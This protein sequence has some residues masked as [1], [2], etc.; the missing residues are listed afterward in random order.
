MCFLF[1]CPN[2][3]LK[4]LTEISKVYRVW[5]LP[6]L[7]VILHHVTMGSSEQP[8]R[9]SVILLSIIRQGAR[10]SK[11]SLFLL[12]VLVKIGRVLLSCTNTLLRLKKCI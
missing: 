6:V 2:S 9:Y 12:Q 8:P 10:K 7:L 11:F 1:L 3:V 5:N 4:I